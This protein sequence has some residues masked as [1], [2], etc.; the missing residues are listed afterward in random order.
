VFDIYRK[1]A[2]I[3]QKLG[4]QNWT[5]ESGFLTKQ[6]GDPQNLREQI[7]RNDDLGHLERD[8]V[9]VAYDLRADLDQLLGRGRIYPTCRVSLLRR[10]MLSQRLLD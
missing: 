6:S 4:D 7:S 3:A 1:L 10:L 5:I 8:I 2:P 9:A